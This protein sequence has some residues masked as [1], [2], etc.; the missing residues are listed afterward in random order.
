MFLDISRQRDLRFAEGLTFY[1]YVLEE[2]EAGGSVSAGELVPRREVD[3]VH[4]P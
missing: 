3:A 1:Q 4:R 2:A